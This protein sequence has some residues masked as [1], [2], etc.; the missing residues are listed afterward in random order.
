MRIIFA[1]TPS[2]ALPTLRALASSEHELALVITREDAPRGRKRVLTES[3]VAAEARAFNLPIL[4]TN[5]LDNALDVIREARADIGVVVAYGALLKPSALKIPRHGWLNIHF[6]EL[7]KWRGAA[8]VQRALMSGDSDISTSIFRLDEGL[9]T[10]DLFSVMQH[11]VPEGIT[12]GDLLDELGQLAPQQL[13]SVLS[14][15]ERDGGAPTPQSG[16]PTYAAKL[17][18]E[19]AR[20]DFT[21]PALEVLNTWAGVTPEPGAYA[22]CNEQPVKLLRVGSVTPHVEIEAKTAALSPGDAQ[23]ING[24]ALVKARD[25][26]IELHEVQPAGKKPMNARDW[27][28]GLS[29][30]ASFS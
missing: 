25:G 23:L 16:T 1:G 4:K 30:S 26:L 9:D 8:P 28:R 18:R 12:A 17:T 22:L 29:G 3:V 7:P 21:R 5:A 13:L 6:S 2:V 19:D 14:D 27:L 24:M 20:L 10:G 11:A 15:I